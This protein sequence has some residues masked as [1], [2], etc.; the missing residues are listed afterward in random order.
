MK[1]TLI[2]ENGLTRDWPS[3]ASMFVWDGSLRDIVIRDCRLEDWSTLFRALSQLKEI[4]LVYPSS[5][6]DFWDDPQSVFSRYGGESIFLISCR[7]NLKCDIVSPEL[8]E[9]DLDPREINN[10]SSLGSLIS[11]MSVMSSVLKKPVLL[12]EEGAHDCVLVD[13][14]PP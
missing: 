1:K 3:M 6:E 10:Q 9:F 12:T 8:I 7:I 13:V 11:I 5:D 4:K 14:Q 2:I